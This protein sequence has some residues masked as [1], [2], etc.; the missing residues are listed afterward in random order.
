MLTKKGTHKFGR[1]FL[2]PGSCCAKVLVLVLEMVGELMCEGT[3]GCPGL[4]IKLLILEGMKET[5]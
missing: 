2:A 5:L 4:Q 3:L 1:A